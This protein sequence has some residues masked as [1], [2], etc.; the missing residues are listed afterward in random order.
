M[1]ATFTL[2]IDILC[3]NIWFMAYYVYIGEQ[4]SDHGL[5]LRIDRGK[6]GGAFDMFQLLECME[7]VCRIENSHRLNYICCICI[8]TVAYFT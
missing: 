2:V 8:Y 4:Q 3:I 6:G 1:H 7:C 5:E